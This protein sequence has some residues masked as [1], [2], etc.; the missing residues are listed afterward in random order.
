MS[1]WSAPIVT[2]PN[3]GVR[4]ATAPGRSVDATPIVSTRLDRWALARIQQSVAS[5]PIQ[6]QLWDGFELTPA[7]G[8]AIASI[9]FK[10]RRALV[11][12]VWDPI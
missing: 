12:W 6:F 1:E 7:T 2:V 5:A 4:P 8:T 10:S 9:R 3:E 11:G